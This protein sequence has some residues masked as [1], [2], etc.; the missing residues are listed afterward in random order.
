MRCV[1]HTCGG[2]EE[3]ELLWKVAVERNLAG[4]GRAL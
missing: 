1:Y 3:K 4:V 2:R